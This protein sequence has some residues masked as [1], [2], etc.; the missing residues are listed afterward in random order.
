MKRRIRD[1]I[2][3]KLFAGGGPGDR[4]VRCPGDVLWEVKIFKA[5]HE[6]DPNKKGHPAVLVEMANGSR[7]WVGG[8]TSKR[9]SSRDDYFKVKQKPRKRCLTN[10][11]GGWWVPTANRDENEWQLQDRVVQPEC[12]EVVGPDELKQIRKMFEQR[13]PRLFGWEPSKRRG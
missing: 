2:D 10:P 6:N 8:T 13:F 4:R 5:D 7:V 1:Q 9:S 12:R 11:N 3:A